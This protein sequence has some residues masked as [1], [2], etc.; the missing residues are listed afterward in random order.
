MFG[1]KK[2]KGRFEDIN[3]TS[4]DSKWSSYA[5][6]YVFLDRGVAKSEKEVYKMN[7]IHSLNWLGYWKEQDKVQQNLQ[8][9]AQ[10]H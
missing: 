9:N 3:P 5:F 8:K 6:I 7:Y 10:S 1:S 2:Q 4:L